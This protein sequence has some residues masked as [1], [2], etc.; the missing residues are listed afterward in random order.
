MFKKPTSARKLHVLTI[1]LITCL[2][3]TVLY[4]KVDQTEMPLD[5]LSYSYDAVM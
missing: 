2:I 4:Y 5:T 1:K 3:L